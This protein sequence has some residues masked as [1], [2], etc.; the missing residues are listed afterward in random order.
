MYSRVKSFSKKVWQH[1][2]RELIVRPTMRPVADTIHVAGLFSTASGIGRSASICANALENSGLRVVRIDLSDVFDQRDLDGPD[3]ELPTLPSTGTLILHLN[4]PEIE[5]AL[6]RMGLFW[7]KRWRV[8]GYWAWELA[9]VPDHW[10]GAERFVSEVWCPSEF[11]ASAIAERIDVPVK[12]VPHAIT[13]P[14]KLQAAPERTNSDAHTFTA[15]VMADGRSSL[16]RKNTSGAIRAFQVAFEGR[17]DAALIIKLRNAEDDASSLDLLQAAESDSRIRVI[18]DAL[19]GGDIWELIRHVDVLLSLHRSEGFGLTMAEAMACG[20]CVMATAYSGNLDFMDDKSACLIPA[21]ET[22]VGGNAGLY[23]QVPGAK[24]A[25][26]DL[27]L[28]AQK[29]RYLADN[30]DA[31]LAIGRAG[32]AR[33]LAHSDGL[34]YLDALKSGSQV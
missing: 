22:D 16:K 25:E 32:R 5:T 24:W 18:D 33:I 29:L 10:C 8:I 27:E 21:A 3:T 23:S 1:A 12:V 11:S 31:R 7:P 15:L 14:D 26:P 30:P 6:I 9:R 13:I 34:S 4:P 28:A 19:A 2:R 20:V 17:D